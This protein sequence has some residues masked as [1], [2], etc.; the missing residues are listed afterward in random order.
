MN[1]PQPPPNQSPPQQLIRTYHAAGL[2]GPADAQFEKDAEKLLQ[3][4]WRVQ[5]IAT[6]GAAMNGTPLTVIAVYVR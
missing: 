2:K 4:G 5:N 6:S 1:R 3:E